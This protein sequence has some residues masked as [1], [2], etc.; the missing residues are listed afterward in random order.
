M[1]PGTPDVTALPARNAPYVPELIPLNQGWSTQW[2]VSYSIGVD[3][4]DYHDGWHTVSADARKGTV[5]FGEEMTPVEARNLGLALLEAARHAESYANTVLGVL[6]SE[7]PYVGIDLPDASTE[8][9]RAVH[10]WFRAAW[11]R[12]VARR[13]AVTR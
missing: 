2:L 4:D 13:D 6:S 9:K 10:G 5:D 12:V 1:A 11:L 8:E 3:P 7:E